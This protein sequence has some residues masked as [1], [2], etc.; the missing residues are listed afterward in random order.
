VQRGFTSACAN[1]RF[2]QLK[3]LFGSL[4]GGAEP[5]QLDAPGEAPNPTADGEQAEE[6]RR[7]D[8]LLEESTPPNNL[9]EERTPLDEVKS[10][11][12]LSPRLNKVV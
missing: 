1:W 7:V 11:H 2:A 12:L 8:I 3:T 5:F 4:Q 9:E 10:A 6:L